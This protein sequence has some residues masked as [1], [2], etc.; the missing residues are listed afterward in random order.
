MGV[1]RPTPTKDHNAAAQALLAPS[2]QDRATRSRACSA[3]ADKKATNEND[4]K[5]I[6]LA[7]LAGAQ[8]ASATETQSRPETPTPAKPGYDT[9]PH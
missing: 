8:P 9:L 6:R 5:D 3:E 1:T 4:R 2:G 7:C